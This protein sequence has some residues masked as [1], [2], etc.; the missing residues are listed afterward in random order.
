MLNLL[1]MDFRH[2]LKSKSVYISLGILIVTTLFTFI[3][4]SILVNPELLQIAVKNDFA[5]IR[6]HSVSDIKESFGELDMLNLFH[7]GNISGGILV[8]LTGIITTLF[9]CSDFKSGFIKNILAAHENKW[10][11]I[12]SKMLV[13]S[14]I[15]L[16]Y[17]AFTF[18]LSLFANAVTGN[19]FIYNN[20]HDTLLYIVTIWMLCNGLCSLVLFICI[21]RRSEG[22]GIGGA[23]IFGSGLAMMILNFLLAVF[24]LDGILDYTL[25]YNL[26]YAPLTYIKIADFRGLIVAVIFTA[27]Y[28]I[29]SKVILSKIDI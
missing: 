27:F 5:I 9:V 15:N 12:L 24:D 14:I 16:F 11:Y 26:A 13:I 7:Q 2:M 1:R 10:N 20:F 8:T 29:F 19:Y 21:A 6:G 18:L 17:I 28:T 23:I 4:F 25:Y 22:V 3:L